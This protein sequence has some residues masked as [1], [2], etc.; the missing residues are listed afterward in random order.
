MAWLRLRAVVMVGTLIE[1]SDGL[2]KDVD[3][4]VA[5]ATWSLATEVDFMVEWMS[6][7]EALGSPSS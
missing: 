6:E 5:P 2:W 3:V 4:I 7:G 1:M